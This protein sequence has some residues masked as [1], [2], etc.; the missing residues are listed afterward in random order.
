M[1]LDHFRN[2]APSNCATETD[3]TPLKVKK[4]GQGPKNL[5]QGCEVFLWVSLPPAV[6]V[7]LQ[8]PLV[9]SS[10]SQISSS[11]S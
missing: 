9:L 4:L 1:P 3:P 11:L 7:L 8:F 2:I 10:P 5:Q 6:S